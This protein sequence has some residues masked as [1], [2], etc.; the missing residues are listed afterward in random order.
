[1]NEEA[2]KQFLRDKPYTEI[3]DL[4]VV[5]QI[6]M[7]KKEEGTVTITITDSLMDRYGITLEDLH[8]QAMQNMDTLQ[9][10]S[11]K[12]MNETMV[13]MFAADIARE[14]G[15][16][17][18][19]AEEIAAQKMSNVP[20]TM[21]VLTNDTKVNGA[22]V[23]LNDDARQEI[24]EKVGDFYVL[25]SSIHET[26]IIPKS[27]GMDLRELE[28]MVQEVNQTQV[29][30]EERLSDHVYV[31][32]AKEHEL[33]RSDSADERIKQKA[34]KRE[35]KQRPSLKNR[36]AEKKNA[37]NKLDLDRDYS[38]VDRKKAVI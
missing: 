15:L 17:I 18:K 31:Y 19:E 24:A 2:N 35:E 21:Y 32:D 38:T 33:F 26:L 11:F 13:E 20:D 12:G 34:E 5:Y 1:M 9:P 16:E 8:E 6:L 22:A 25:P 4:A 7:D 23:I 10:Y 30:P 37:F 3:E 28:Q 27:A 14:Q 36:L 29:T